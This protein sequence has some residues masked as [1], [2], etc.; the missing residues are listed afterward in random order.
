MG[1]QSAVQ[2]DRLNWV[3][4]AKGLGIVLVVAAHVWTRGAVRDAIYAF[5]MP[6]FFLLSGY[7]VRPVPIRGLVIAQVRTL[8]V[9]FLVFSVLLV[10]ADVLIEGA[11]GARPM[12]AGWVQALLTI[13]FRT[14][15][16]RGPFTILW[17]VPCL[18]VARLLWT[19]VALRVPS[20]FDPRWPLL[21]LALLA[22]AFLVGPGAP[23]PMG[24][25]GVPAALAMF[26]AGQLWRRAPD[27]P[28]GAAFLIIVVALAILPLLPPLNLKGGAFGIPIVSL[29]AAALV[30]V[31]LCLALMR[32]RPPVLA[33]LAWLGRASLVIMFVHVAFVHYLAPYWPRPALFAAAL[34][35]GV[36]IHVAARATR[37]SRA[38]MLGQWASRA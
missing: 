37:I 33:A 18:F 32:Q 24:I 19:M 31:A 34:A 9:P 14:D 35:G 27:V 10:A 15:L 6:L 28:S 22:A 29:A 30:S 12:F 13:I 5:H 7:L 17:F 1:E 25:L 4:A 21:V 16:T 2:S 36:A 11:R 23:S 38:L 3:D 26:W 8:L 20:P